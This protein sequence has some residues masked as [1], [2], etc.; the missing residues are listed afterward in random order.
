MSNGLVVRSRPLN[1][2]PWT[3]DSPELWVDCE[4]FARIYRRS[5]RTVRVWCITGY[6]LNFGIAS[7]QDITGKWWIRLEG[8]A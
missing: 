7:Y 4:E 1:L 3:F 8:K 5:P 2:P 6:V